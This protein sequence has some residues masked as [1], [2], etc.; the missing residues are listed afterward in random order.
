M[1]L[2]QVP[3]FYQIANRDHRS[4]PET[5]RLGLRT[6]PGIKKHVEL[7]VCSKVSMYVQRLKG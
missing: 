3:T 5:C 2:R 1:T 6:E 7:G 4:A